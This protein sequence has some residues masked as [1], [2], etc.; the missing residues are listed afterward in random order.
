MDKV[1][2]PIR[3]IVVI[4]STI[5]VIASCSNQQTE[6][7]ISELGFSMK[8]PP[9]WKLGRSATM[10][11]FTFQK[12]CYFV[13]AGGRFCFASVR[14]MYPYGSVLH[15]SL[16]KNKS[17]SEYVDTAKMLCG[18]KIHSQTRRTVCGL[19]AIEMVYESAFRKSINSIEIN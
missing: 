16:S 11:E 14:E 7:K 15:S 18:K 3:W 2:E 4:L 10:Q 12:R 19:E 8:V 17:L 6:I 5:L 9:E 1:S 13:E